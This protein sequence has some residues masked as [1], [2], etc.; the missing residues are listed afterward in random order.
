MKRKLFILGIFITILFVLPPIL[1]PS[2]H[3]GSSQK[4]AIRAD[5]VKMGHPYQSFTAL[6]KSN[7]M[8]K[9]KGERFEVNWIDFNSRTGTPTIFYVKKSKDGYKVVS[10]GTGP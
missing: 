3:D 6:I 9:D 1:A 7:G 2:A 10:A 4:S 8:D 5:L